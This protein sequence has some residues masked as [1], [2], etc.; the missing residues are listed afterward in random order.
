MKTYQI[1]AAIIWQR[2]TVWGLNLLSMLILMVGWIVPGFVARAFFNLLSGTAEAGLTLWTL[3]AAMVG[4]VLARAVGLYGLPNTNRP[5]GENSRIMLQ[6]NV[7]ARVL[8]LPGAQALPESPGQAV[9]RLRDDALELP[10]FGMW[11]NDGIGLGVQTIIAI[12]VMLYTNWQITLI[13][14]APMVIILLSANRLTSRCERYRI[15]FREAT[16]KTS[17]FIAETFGAAQAVKIAGAEERMVANFRTLNENRRKAGLIDRLFNELLESIWVNASAIGAGVTL[18]ASASA[19]KAGT[20][21]VGD[22]AL[23]VY[24]MGA[25]G[26]FTGFL[27]FLTARYKQAGVGVK[28]LLSLMGDAPHSELVTSTPV[29]ERGD[30]PA[31]PFVPKTAEHRLHSLEVRGLSYTH[32]TSG[33]GVQDIGFELQRGQFVVITGRIGSGKTTLVRALLGL[34]PRDAGTVLWNGQPVPDLAEHFIPPRC[35][36]TAQVPRLFS[37]SLQDN[38][39]MGIPAEQVDMP[40]A[41]QA[42]VMDRDLISLE[43]GLDTMVGPK[44]VRLS[45]GQIQRS[46]AARMFLRQPEL[47]VFDDLSSALDVETER[48][49]WQRLDTS[50]TCL[51]VSHRHTALRRADHIIV[52]KDGRIEAQ[53]KLDDLLETSEEMRELWREEKE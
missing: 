30:F 21:T 23:F 12:S 43:K 42:A 11:L 44:G 47:L 34:L 4:C 33:R 16:G 8:K 22:F 35:A 50:A 26:E 13:V 38:L 51:V 52:L 32:P 48:Q 39:L 18:I 45:G 49:L 36:Y 3:I 14:L 37:A 27:G 15:A 5:F 41:M 9:N 6:R 29:Y 40:A 10:M 2:R 19:I 28:R 1:I 24:N 46:A 25:I 20:F 7:L 17:G 53:G 31:I